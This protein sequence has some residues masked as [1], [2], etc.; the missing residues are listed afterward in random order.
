M[1][2]L[3]TKTVQASKKQDSQRVA[4]EKESSIMFT[5]DFYIYVCL[6][7]KNFS[8]SKTTMVVKINI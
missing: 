1:Q 7:N 4:N 8:T 3:N 2:N 6:D 5:L